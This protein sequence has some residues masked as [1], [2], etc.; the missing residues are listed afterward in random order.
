M[1][2]GGSFKILLFFMHLSMAKQGQMD[3]VHWVGS[4]VGFFVVVVWG[5]FVFGF[6]SILGG[7]G[8]RSLFVLLIDVHSPDW[9]WLSSWFSVSQGKKL[10]KPN[11]ACCL[12]HVLA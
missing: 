8:I 12:D 6:G 3:A 9:N 1:H 7:K 10:P 5:G 4:G 2:G 11:D